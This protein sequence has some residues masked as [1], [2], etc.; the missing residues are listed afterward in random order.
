MGGQGSMP[1]PP[2]PQLQLCTTL[3]QSI[4]V[5]VHGKLE[6]CKPNRHYCANNCN[7]QTPT[8]KDT[9]APHGT[10]ALR[11]FHELAPP[12]HLFIP[13]KGYTY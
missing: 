3:A 11:T 10:R 7:F 12:Q 5:V 1:P 4:Y 9:H 8:P 13:E 6:S 2:H